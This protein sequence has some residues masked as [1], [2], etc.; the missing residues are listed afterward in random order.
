MKKILASILTILLVFS[1]VGC[2]SKEEKEELIRDEVTTTV[3]GFMSTVKT[4]DFDT[5]NTYLAEDSEKLDNSNFGNLDDEPIELVKTALD[6]MTYEISNIEVESKDSATIDL[7]VFAMKLDL[8]N[9][10]YSAVTGKGME[11]KTVETNLSI[12]AI[13]AK[14]E[15]GE[16]V[17]LL[18]INSSEFSNAIVN[19]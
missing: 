13:K 11:G 19:Q 15:A 17:W 2:Q 8:T 12:P 4:M 16:N 6:N 3:N 18:S 5:A 7:K 14:N 10:V 9:T 1:L